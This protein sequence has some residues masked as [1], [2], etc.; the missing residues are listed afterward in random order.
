MNLAGVKVGDDVMVT[1]VNRKEPQREKVTAIEPDTADA[2]I[3]VLGNNHTPERIKSDA[4]R[5]IEGCAGRLAAVAREA[6]GAVTRNR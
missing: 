3:A 2:V 4:D 1:D 6:L 5:F